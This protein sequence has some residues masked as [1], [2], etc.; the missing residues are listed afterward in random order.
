[1]DETIWKIVA[2]DPNG[3]AVIPPET[4]SWTPIDLANAVVIGKQRA[5]FLTPSD[6]PESDQAF[7]RMVRPGEGG[8][9]P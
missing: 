6:L 2:A 5:L 7:F 4:R 3:I 1:L 8:E 9:A